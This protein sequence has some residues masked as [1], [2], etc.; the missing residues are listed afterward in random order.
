[1][2]GIALRSARMFSDIDLREAL[3][4]GEIFFVASGAE[5]ARI[6]QLGHH[7]RRIINVFLKWTV[8]GLTVHVCVLARLFLFH[9]IAMAVSAGRVS[10]I[11]C[12]TRHDLLQRVSTVMAVLTKAFRDEVG[13]ERNE[14]HEAGNE[15]R[16]KPEKVFGIFEL[17]QK[18]PLPRVATGILQDVPGY[19]DCSHPSQ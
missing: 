15:Y 1:M 12:R 4:L 3:G 2:A 19:C 13:S 9:Y 11:V 17:C 16:R 18:L 6:R 10:R 7:A 8:A 14:Q 5:N